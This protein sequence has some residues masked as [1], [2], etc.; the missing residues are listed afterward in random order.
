MGA[1]D[2]AVSSKVR[3]IQIYSTISK[4]QDGRETAKSKEIPFE[5]I[6]YFYELNVRSS[7]GPTGGG[8]GHQSSRD[9]GVSLPPE[10]LQREAT[11]AR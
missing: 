1:P 10:S 3:L 9:P 4:L 8:E 2:G 5:S 11:A 7:H 6:Q